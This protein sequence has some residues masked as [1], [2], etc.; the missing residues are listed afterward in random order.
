MHSEIS[1]SG[2]LYWVVTMVLLILVGVFQVERIQYNNPSVQVLV[3]KKPSW[4]TRHPE[5][6]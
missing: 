3:E 4:L 6:H 5:A 2:A 1:F